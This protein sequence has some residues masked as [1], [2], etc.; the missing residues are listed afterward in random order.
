M[1]K[2]QALLKYG[3]LDGAK[4]MGSYDAYLQTSAGA[5]ARFEAQAQQTAAMVGQSMDGLRMSAFGVGS[6]LLQLAANNASLV[7]PTMAAAAAFTALGMATK[8]FQWST[9]ATGVG[10]VTSAIRGLGTAA[11]FTAAATTAGVAVATAGLAAL[12]GYVV[13][14]L[15]RFDRE[16][17]AAKTTANDIRESRVTEV[18]DKDGKKTG[19]LQVTF[20]KPEA[21]V[22]KDV[23]KSISLVQQRRERVLNREASK[24]MPESWRRDRIGGN[25][26]YDE[27]PTSGKAYIEESPDMRDASWKANVA[28]QRG[29]MSR[30]EELEI[31]RRDRSYQAA[32]AGQKDITDAAADRQY[33]RYDIEHPSN[34]DP[35]KGK[36]G[37]KKAKTPLERMMDKARRQQR[38]IARDQYEDLDAEA[39]EAGAKP[40]ERTFITAMEAASDQEKAVDRLRRGQDAAFQSLQK[41]G[42]VSTS[43]AQAQRD[44]ADAYG[45][46]AGALPEAVARGKMLEQQLGSF[47]MLSERMELGEVIQ[48]RF[49]QV[50]EAS[51]RMQDAVEEANAVLATPV[52]MD[53]EVGKT[54]HARTVLIEKLTREAKILEDEAKA[55][56]GRPGANQ[57]T[58]DNMRAQAGE[59]RGQAN[60]LVS[61]GESAKEAGNLASMYGAAA[62]ASA[63][64]KEEV[65][66]L[67]RK[68]AAGPDRDPEFLRAMQELDKAIANP[69]AAKQ[70]GITTEELEKLRAQMRRDYQLKLVLDVQSKVRDFETEARTRVAMA[71]AKAERAAAQ[72]GTFGSGYQVSDD[73][74]ERIEAINQAIREAKAAG[75]TT[76]D[77]QKLEGQ[78]QV[79]VDADRQAQHSERLQRQAEQ[80]REAWTDGV[81]NIR[82]SFNEFFTDLL[83]K[84]RTNFR[85]F[86]GSVL[87][88]ISQMLVKMSLMR[89]AAQLFKQDM[90]DASGEVGSAP[91]RGGLGSVLAGLGTIIR[92][93]ATGQKPGAAQAPAAV[94]GAATAS[95]VATSQD[96]GATPTGT[97]VAATVVGNAPASV[98]AATTTG[99]RTLRR[100]AEAAAAVTAGPGGP[101]DGP[102][103]GGDAVGGAAGSAG[104]AAAA[105]I[106]AGG[107]QGFVAG[108]VGVQ[109]V[110]VVEIVTGLRG[111]LGRAVG[112]SRRRSRA[113]RASPVAASSAWAGR[114]PGARWRTGPPGPGWWRR[115]GSWP[116]TTRAASSA[117]RARTRTWRPTRSWPSW[118]RA[119]RC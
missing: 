24:R 37:G 45:R 14:I 49:T 44:L 86:M 74:L 71:K 80:V 67:Q 69:A 34:V 79:L 27:N 23:E 20:A 32:L 119:R 31:L 77:I 25:N 12:V 18:R 51:R 59:K 56:E 85:E 83:T 104:A 70:L 93:A 116:C 87:Q 54:I 57:I 16:K 9:I 103:A 66:G 35:D 4:A 111:F 101:G 42:K 46:S 109:D 10:T 50:A 105:A 33:Q 28:A 113:Y 2:A 52:G 40:H 58:V 17:N 115:R 72:T 97:P 3:M 73:V 95:P 48:A 22:T 108:G 38:G 118:S 81:Q 82:Q 91:K 30:A 7:A 61:T 19:K 36:K 98:E 88:M 55:M 75:G 90:T 41:G 47:A 78:K 60:F 112:P 102:G 100:Q 21:E 96:Q 11:G 53:P 84:G 64:L 94:A 110:R 107:R 65:D 43:V 76:D 26:P 29:K 5:M 92:A 63:K 106:T 117:A 8:G 114:R 62:K 99:A 39:V 13:W 15:G 89:L 6:S 68:M 1:Q